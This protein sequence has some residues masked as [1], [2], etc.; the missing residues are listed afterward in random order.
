M[1]GIFGEQ[2]Q[3]ITDQVPDF[4]VA[5]M[6]DGKQFDLL[7]YEDAPHA[8]ANDTRA[9]YRP[10][11]P[12]LLSTIHLHSCMNNWCNSFFYS[13]TVVVL[14]SRSSFSILS[15]LSNWGRVNRGLFAVHVNRQVQEIS[16]YSR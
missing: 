13:Y 2:D 7:I 16:S 15:D 8:F 1:L 9:S 4:A 14:I 5:M 6:K 10:R 11:L 3:R 12:R